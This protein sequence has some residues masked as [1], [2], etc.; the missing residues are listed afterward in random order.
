MAHI[1]SKSSRKS[2]FQDRLALGL[3]A[4]LVVIA[5]IGGLVAF[6]LVRNFVD[7]WKLT[8]LPGDPNPQS[9]STQVPEVA[10][11]TP[12]PTVASNVPLQPAS[13]PTPQPWDGVSRV[14]VLVMGLDYRDWEA[15]D[16]PPRT[17]TMVLFT[18]DPLSKT[19]GMLSIPRDMWVNVPGFDYNK[20]NTAYFLGESFKLPGGGPG[21]AMKTVEEFLGVPIQ[22][23]AQIDFTT[24]VDF[25]DRIDGITITVPQEIIVDPLGPGNTVTLKPGEQHIYGPVALAYARQR[26]TANGDIDRAARQQ[27]VIMGIRNRVLKASVFPRLLAQAPQ[28]YQD[29]SSGIHTN[30]TLDQAVQLALLVAQIPPDTIRQ[31]VIGTDAF[32]FGKSPD[33]LDILKPI[34]DKIRLIRDEVFTTGG[35][36]G[37][38][39]VAQDPAEL[40]KAE[41]ARISVQN[42]TQTPGLAS[43]TSQYFK[44][45]GINVVEETNAELKSSTV[46]IMYSSKPYTAAYLAKMM[47]IPDSHIFSRSDPPNP[48]IDLAVI[49]GNDW[50][51]MTPTP[52]K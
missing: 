24:F 26:E 48:Q 37:P 1:Q 3:L 35:P 14:N 22:Y 10:G 4:A 46:L 43:R 47:N 20:I 11:G 28:L 25:V 5:I 9:S 49:L 32:T 33:G 36:V 7:S 41:N 17:D 52:P 31:R 45:L 6:N 29:L 23:Y 2:L 12:A 30:M 44:S 8:G 40:M 39:A 18:L 13:G 38:A 19:A 21:L 34:P 16:G 50:V 27:Q 51:T 42:G 15:S